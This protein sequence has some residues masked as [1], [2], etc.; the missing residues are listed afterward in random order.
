MM[1]SLCLR[2]FDCE[3]CLI[4]SH[5]IVYEISH[6]SIGI[7]LSNDRFSEGKEELTLA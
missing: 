6:R 7:K 5:N 4:E 2:D 1:F 3:I